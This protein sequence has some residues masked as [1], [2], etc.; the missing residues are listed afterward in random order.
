V[1]IHLKDGG[2]FII[3]I[4]PEHTKKNELHLKNGYTYTSK[5]IFKNGFAYKTHQI[6]KGKKVIAKQSVKAIRLPY[7]K[8]KK[9]LR[10]LGFMNFKI[11]RSNQFTYCHYK[12]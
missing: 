11:D 3:N 10:K 1:A 9:E 12:K 8:V 5:L 4:Q 6:L 7:E 2:L